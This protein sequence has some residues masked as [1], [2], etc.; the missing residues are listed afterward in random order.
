MNRRRN[1]VGELFKLTVRVPITVGFLAIVFPAVVIV[2]YYL[3]PANRGDLTFIAAT[4]VATASLVSAFFVSRGLKN[5]ADSQRET[6]TLSFPAR[7][8]DPSFF[9]RKK[10]VR[11]L[12]DK[13]YSPEITNLLEKRQKMEE[14]I[15]ENPEVKVHLIDLFNFF[16][17][18][19]V[20]VDYGIVDVDLL[21]DFF[22]SIFIAH[23]EAFEFWLVDRQSNRSR[24][25]SSLNMLYHRWLQ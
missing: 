9:E 7:W 24:L 11:D 12:R 13:L 6:R 19:A 22:R 1:V 14:L 3:F 17:E 21:R 15:R 8:N 4:L 18:M 23:Y 5:N 10:A 16:E 25:F 2:S 20:C